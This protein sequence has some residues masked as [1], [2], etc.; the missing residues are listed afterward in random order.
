M[1]VCDLTGLKDRQSEAAR[2]MGSLRGD[3][4]DSFE[5]QISHSMDR[6]KFKEQLPE[7]TSDWIRHCQMVKR[8]EQKNLASVERPSQDD[9]GIHEIVL[10]NL[11]AGGDFILEGIEMLGEDLSYPCQAEYVKAMTTRLGM[12][13]YLWHSKGEV[14]LAES[15]AFIAEAFK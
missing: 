11:I 2:L 12:D 8:W 9:L 10:N 13:H 5:S 7:F 4:G 15:D 14:S 3:S 1:K 6:E